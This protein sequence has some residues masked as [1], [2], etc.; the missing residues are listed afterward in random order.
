MA[1]V[2]SNQDFQVKRIA[3]SLGAE[4][5]GIDLKKL[6]DTKTK[7]IRDVFLENKVIFFRDQ[8][9]S[10]E[11]YLT[12]ASKLGQPSPYPM[13]PGIEGFPEITQ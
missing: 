6:D 12:F 9:L 11:E 8:Q 1:T 13:V 4:I 3:G 5:H 10:P 2:S 7:Q